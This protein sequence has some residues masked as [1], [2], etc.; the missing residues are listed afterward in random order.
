MLPKNITV[1]YKGEARTFIESKGDTV[2]IY[3]LSIITIYFLL[4]LLYN[5]FKDP[6]IILT[7]VP[8]SLFGA[9][10]GLFLV[11]GSFNLYTNIAIFTLFGLITKHGILLVDFANKLPKYMSAKERVIEAA[12]LRFRPII[13][14][15][16]SMVAAATPLALTTSVG[17]VSRNQVGA[18]IV[19]GLI[20]GTLLTLFVTPIFY[21]LLNKS[22]KTKVGLS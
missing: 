13:M 7:T 9:L 8:L 15:T 6:L 11:K 17:C 10:L 14:T 3:G 16:V 5:N 22:K 12:K 20:I 4:A 18:V 2:L 19:S 1:D 21:V